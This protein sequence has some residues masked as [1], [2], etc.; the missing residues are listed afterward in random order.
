M[1]KLGMRLLYLGH[2]HG[3]AVKRAVLTYEFAAVDGFDC[4]SG[5]CRAHLLN[6]NRVVMVVSVYG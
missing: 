2:L 5:H 6:S 1:L 3:G 4:V